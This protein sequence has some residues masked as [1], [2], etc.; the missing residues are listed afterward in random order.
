MPAEGLE[1]IYSVKS[2]QERMIM[3]NKEIEKILN[4]EDGKKI[5]TRQAYGDKLAELGGW[6]SGCHRKLCHRRKRQCCCQSKAQ[7]W[8]VSGQT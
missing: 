1:A 4:K 6:K 3:I 2:L 8:C 5:A 7:S